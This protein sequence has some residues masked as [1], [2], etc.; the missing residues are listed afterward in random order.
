MVS[1]ELGL[2]PATPRQYNLEQAYFTFLMKASSLVKWGT[3][4]P[5]S[6]GFGVRSKGT[7]G[8]GLSKVTW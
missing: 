4:T 3:R 7:K 1:K 6:G 2:N 8:K 5:T